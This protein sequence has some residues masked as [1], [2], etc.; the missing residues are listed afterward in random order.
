[1]LTLW[2]A[3]YM[4]R[5]HHSFG[6]A[7]GILIIASLSGTAA[8]QSS[9]ASRAS[10]GVLPATSLAHEAASLFPIGVGISDRIDEHAEDWPL[11]ISQF[12]TVTPE[13]CMKPQSLQRQPGKVRLCPSRP[14]RQICLKQGPEDRRPL[15]SLG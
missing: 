14:L 2:L 5:Y 7:V 3:Q 6:A 11:L 15:L 13:N 10:A 9:S 8:G 1:M 12:K 4:N